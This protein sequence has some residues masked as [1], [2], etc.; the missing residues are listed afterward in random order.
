MALGS[1][2]R[3]TRTD[4]ARKTGIFLKCGERTILFMSSQKPRALKTHFFQKQQFQ[5]D[6]ISKIENKGYVERR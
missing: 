1:S 5:D 3:F 2:L 6:V 4:L